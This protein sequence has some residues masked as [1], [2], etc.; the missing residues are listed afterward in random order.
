MRGEVQRLSE[1]HPGEDE[2][3]SARTRVYI[4]RPLIRP[5]MSLTY[6][7]P[8]FPLARKRTIPPSDAMPPDEPS[9]TTS[10]R[11]TSICRV[12]RVLFVRPSQPRLRRQQG[13]KVE[14]SRQTQ[15]RAAARKGK[16]RRREAPRRR[17]RRRSSSR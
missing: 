11:T 2:G 9:Y 6:A 10:E 3:A 5:A 17:S 12:S 13:K 14:R 16:E 15:Q 1:I 4:T 8:S 7:S